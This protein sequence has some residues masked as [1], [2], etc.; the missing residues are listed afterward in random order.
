MHKD[1]YGRGEA[2]FKV[3][4]AQV[5]ASNSKAECL[6]KLYLTSTGIQ[7]WSDYMQRQLS[8]REPGLATALG[9]ISLP[10]RDAVPPAT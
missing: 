10:K 7:R 9:V 5:M 1:T 8:M 3:E 2:L 4:E 6:R